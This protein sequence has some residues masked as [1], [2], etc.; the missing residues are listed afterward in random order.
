MAECEFVWRRGKRVSQP[1]QRAMSCWLKTMGPDRNDRLSTGFWQWRSLSSVAL[2]KAIDSLK[3]RYNFV[4][5]LS[6]S[7]HRCSTNLG[8][9]LPQLV[10]LSPGG[11]SIDPQGVTVVDR[12]SFGCACQTGKPARDSALEVSLLKALDGRLCPASD[13]DKD[14]ALAGI[15]LVHRRKRSLPQNRSNRNR[16]RAFQSLHLFCETSL[17]AL[18][19]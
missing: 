13:R 19:R 1:S 6:F 8:D 11:E 9:N 10:E 15:S 16:H 17:Q 7:C 3:F 12:R 4:G 2:R 5:L 14:A 18:H